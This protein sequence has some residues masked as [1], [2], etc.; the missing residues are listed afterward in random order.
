MVVSTF[1]L[2][3]QNS[4]MGFF[5]CFLLLGLT[6]AMSAP[7]NQCHARGSGAK[8]EHVYMVWCLLPG[9]HSS[10]PVN[11]IVTS[12]L[13][14]APR[15]VSQLGLDVMQCLVSAWHPALGTA[16][17]VLAG[18][19]LNTVMLIDANRPQSPTLPMVLEVPS[20]LKNYLS[21]LEAEVCTVL[22]E[23]IVAISEVR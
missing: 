2:F 17:L 22:C 11:S 6:N 7:C 14:A 23:G 13:V 21:F 10:E 4:A 5:V 9:K 1:P 12:V 20:M 15:L 18:G 16:F 8:S 3:L 19:S